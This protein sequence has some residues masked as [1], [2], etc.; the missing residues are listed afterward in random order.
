MTPMPTAHVLQITT[1]V[2]WARSPNTLTLH[3]GPDVPRPVTA[4]S[5]F[6]HHGGTVVLVNVASRG[7][8]IPGGRLEAGESPQQALA[9]EVREEAGVTLGPHRVEPAGYNHLHSHGT[10]APDSSYPHPDSY[11]MF[12]TAQLTH[13]ASLR[14]L[15]PHEIVDVRWVPASHVV[16]LAGPRSWTAL[17]IHL[18]NAGT[19]PA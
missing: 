4:A 1:N 13:R 9:R 6:V 15:V 16:G 14:T 7:W 11:Q 8:D 18:Q 19:I 5:A 2:L 10:P 12:Y 17:Y 3:A